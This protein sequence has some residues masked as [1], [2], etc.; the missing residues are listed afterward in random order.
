[1]EPNLASLLRAAPSLR[2]LSAEPC[3]DSGCIGSFSSL[4]F[5]VILASQVLVA[6]VTPNFNFCLLS[7][8]EFAESFV[9]GKWVFFHPTDFCLFLSLVGTCSYLWKMWVEGVCIHFT[10]HCPLKVDGHGNSDIFIQIFNKIS[11]L[12]LFQLF[13]AWDSCDVR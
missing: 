4:F 11:V 5:S 3:R 10:E 6:S 9:L 13:M 8:A 7:S 2:P 1:M 12:H